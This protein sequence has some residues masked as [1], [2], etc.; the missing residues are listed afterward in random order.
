M[1]AI[2]KAWS[3]G[4][5][6]RGEAEEANEQM[7]KESERLREI[8]LLREENAELK[9]QLEECQKHVEWL[10]EAMNYQ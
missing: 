10:E 1:G 9:K 5:I 3:K 7:R 6:D 4:I 2:G 8:K